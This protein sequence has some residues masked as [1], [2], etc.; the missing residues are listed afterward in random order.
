M[1]VSFGA[2][3]IH[4]YQVVAS[5]YSIA[6][7]G[8]ISSTMKLRKVHSFRNL[9]EATIYQTCMISTSKIGKKK[10]TL[11]MRCAKIECGMV[12]GGYTKHVCT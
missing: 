12:I 3:A 1:M 4:T 11:P 6:E 9:L 5:L 7:I 2:R 10:K 8:K